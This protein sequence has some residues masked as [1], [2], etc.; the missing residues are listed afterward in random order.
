M[1]T[2]ILK[3][4]LLTIDFDQEHM[5]KFLTYCREK[6]AGDTVEPKHVEKLLKEYHDH[7]PIWWYTHEYSLYCMLNRA[8]RLMEVDLIIKMGFFVRD[9][10]NHITALHVEQRN[11]QNHSNSFIVYRGQGLSALDFDQL[12]K[13]R[14]GL[15]SFNNFLSTSLDRAVSLAFAE[16]NR[17]N[18][19]LV[20]VLFEIT[21]NPSISSSPFANVGNVS[22]F[23]EEE[24]LFTMH[25]VFRIGRVEQIDKNGRLWQVELT[26][27]GDNDPQLYALTER[28]R[29]ETF[30]TAKGW[31]RLGILLIRLGHFDKA[32][33]VFG[34]MLGQTTEQGEKAN[35]YHMLGLIKN[36]QGKYEE[37]VTIYGTALEIKERTLPANHSSLA[38]SYI[39]IG[40]VHRSMGEYSKALSSYEKALEIFQK[41]LSANHPHLATSYNNLG[42]VYDDIGEYSKALSYHEQALEIYRKTL[43]ANHPNLAASYNNIGTVYYN[44]GEDLKAL[45]FYEKALEIQQKT[46]PTDHPGFATSYNNIGAVYCNMH[47]YS[48]ALSYYEKAV[49]IREKILPANHPDLATS[50]NNIGRAYY[51]MDETSKALFYYEKS[52]Q[53]CQTTLPRNHP[54]LSASYYNIS[55]VY[56]K[57]G[58]YSNALS[59]YVRALNMW[60]RSLPLN[61]PHLQRARKGIE[62]VKKKM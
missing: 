27:T 42:T 13:T 46:L 60:Q 38:T 48:K 12:K 2:Q 22:D 50:Y 7:Q 43:P 31:Y 59:Y 14:G 56:D 62:I 18:P 45:S 39:S 53:I 9:L 8:L 35:I 41:I 28:I 17:E 20:G 32:E 33:Q 52:L 51:D 26:L 11:G 29:E 24:I 6:L 61:H 30:P 37:A 36:N 10:H 58:K 15:M 47:E 55:G 54:H 5:N 4:I 25:S 34:I 1:Y 44:M 40:E 57:M 19:D 49:E 23:Q 21:I 16:S 3:E